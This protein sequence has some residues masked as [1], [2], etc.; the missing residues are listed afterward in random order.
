MLGTGWRTWQKVAVG[1]AGAI[2][3]AVLVDGPGD[4]FDKARRGVKLAARGV[5]DPHQGWFVVSNLHRPWLAEVGYGVLDDAKA[6]ERGRYGASDHLD[7]DAD[8]FRHAYAAALMT[9]RAMRDHGA[10]Q[11][12]AARLVTGLGDAHE[13]DGVDNGAHASEM[14]RHNNRVGVELVGD[15]RQGAGWVTEAQVEQLVVDALEA[16]RLQRLADDGSGLVATD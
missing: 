15:G 16:G 4:A 9:V 1:V 3:V 2:G 8:A 14:D 7:D 5:Q 6:A 11:A 12:E 10:T 13:R